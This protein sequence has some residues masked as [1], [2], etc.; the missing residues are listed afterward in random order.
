MRGGEAVLGLESSQC[1]YSVV[2]RARDR[3]GW[4]P[5]RE[6][7]LETTTVV[8]HDDCLKPAM[9]RTMRETGV[10]WNHLP[11][12]ESICTKCG[13]QQTIGRVAAAFPKHF[14]FFPRSWSLPVQWIKLEHYMKTTGAKKG[15]TLIV[16]PNT[17]SRGRGIY[18]TQKVPPRSG[19]NLMVQVY[20]E[21]PLLISGLKFDLRM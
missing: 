5:T 2:S 15:V 3:L 13:L 14:K 21:R 12:I 16:K 4:A 10:R 8:W 1:Q 7:E 11:G 19:E 17:L 20:V 18:L 6:I 9:I